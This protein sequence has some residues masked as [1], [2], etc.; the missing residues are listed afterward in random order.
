MAS[1][2]NG[3]QIML[4][5]KDLIRDV[6]VFVWRLVPNSALYVY[7]AASPADSALRLRIETVKDLQYN[8]GPRLKILKQTLRQVRAPQCNTGNFFL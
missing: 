2:G 7:F 5:V 1:R 3:R 4:H 6:V 8:V